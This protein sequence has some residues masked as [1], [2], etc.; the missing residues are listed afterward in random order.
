MIPKPCEFCGEVKS[1]GR[2]VEA[3]L[4]GEVGRLRAIVDGLP[5]NRSGS[6]PISCPDSVWVIFGGVLYDGNVEYCCYG[7]WDIDYSDGWRWVDYRR[8]AVGI[9]VR[10]E[11]FD[12]YDEYYVPF[13]YSWDSREEAEAYC[14]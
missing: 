13:D 9:W 1:F 3:N 14:G 6:L 7:W 12:D 4:R 5:V 11:F 2:E 8:W 10:D